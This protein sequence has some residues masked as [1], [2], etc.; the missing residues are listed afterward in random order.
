[1]EELRR[2]GAVRDS[3]VVLRSLLEEPLE[4]GA[5][6]LGPVSLVTVRQQQREP[7]RLAPLR[8]TRDE[9]LVDHDL[10]AV[11]EVA[12][13]RFPENKRVG[14]GY[15]VAVLEADRGVFRKRR[16]VDLE[17]GAG[18]GEMLDRRIRLTGVRVV[19]HEVAVGERAAL[20]ILAREA[21]G[22]AVLEQ[23]GV[24]ERL[25]LAP[26]YPAVDNGLAATVELL[27]ELDVDRE[28]WRH[29]QQLL[30]QGAQAIGRNCGD[31]R[32]AGH[33]GLGRLRHG[34][35]RRGLTDRR[36]ELLVGGAQ[37][38]GDVGDEC[39]GFLGRDHALLD[40]PCG[41]DGADG[42]LPLDPL[43]HQRLRVRRVVLLVVAEAPVSHEVDHEVVAEFG[44]VREG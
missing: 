36:P 3:D 31:N 20:G 6:V 42:R 23:R 25:T 7:R 27:R 1:M 28:P 18:P 19:K 15:R 30:V 13:L 40:E 41:V 14:C 24:G 44:S 11:D 43:D 4:P 17:G 34:G 29:G 35:G 37:R 22:D 16:I 9:E 38:R 21:H 2:G 12:E 32:V 8:A 39:L 26:V 33:H 5:R 10:G